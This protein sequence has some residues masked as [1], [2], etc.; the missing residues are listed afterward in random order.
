MTMKAVGLEN[1]WRPVRT[2]AR[3]HT[4]ASAVGRSSHPEALNMLAW[5]D[6]HQ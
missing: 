1:R 4:Q 3:L 6:D 2:I 5:L